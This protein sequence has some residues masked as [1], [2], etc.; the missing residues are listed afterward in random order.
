M[1]RF[2][3]SNILD[4]LRPDGGPAGPFDLILCRNVLIYFAQAQAV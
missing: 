3:Y 2:S 1:V 4:L